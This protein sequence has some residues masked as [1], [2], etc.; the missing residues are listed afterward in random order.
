[1]TVSCWLRSSLFNES[2][3]NFFEPELQKRLYEMDRDDSFAAKV[4]SALMELLPGG[5]GAVDD[6]ARKLGISR[7]TLQRKLTEENT[8]FQKQLN[9]TRE[10][11]AKNY[12]KNTEM[13]SDDIAFL[14]GYQELNSFLRAFNAW[15]GMSVSEYK[16]AND[17]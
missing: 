10:L 12:I 13:S 2:M 15:T 16:I 7:R 8:S 6:V 17:V 11:L 5:A 3:W 14:L 9:G 1:M 4:R